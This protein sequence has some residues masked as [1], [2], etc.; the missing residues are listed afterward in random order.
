M[1][2]VDRVRHSLSHCDTN[3]HALLVSLGFPRS[4]DTERRNVNPTDQLSYVL[5]TVTSVVERIRPA[6]LKDPT[7]CDGFTVADLLAHVMSLG[8]SCADLY[9]GT[10]LGV[11][12][13][14]TDSDDVPADDFRLVMEDLL[15]AA[16]SPGAM[17]R[18]LQ[19]PMGEMTGADLARLIAL[20]GLVH[21]RDLA[22]STGDSLE[23]PPCVIDAVDTFARGALTN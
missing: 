1:A 17:D 2:H 20:D 19:T 12:Y 18:V 4:T 11:T 10:E 6:Q 13:T 7:P 15:A 5:P 9:R 14:P 16:K 8:S 21:G 23:L 22:T 3:C